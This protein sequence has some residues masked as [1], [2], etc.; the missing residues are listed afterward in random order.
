MEVTEQL[1]LIKQK[2]LVFDIET[3]K[4]FHEIAS[5]SDMGVAV[6]VAY[7]CLSDKYK[8]FTEDNVDELVS[9][10]FNADVVVGYNII[11]FDYSVLK[12]YTNKDFSSL[13]TI[14]MMRI[15][16]KGLG[17]RP[18]LD[19][20][21]SATL[22]ASK[23]ADGLQSLRWYKQG[24]IDKIIEYC[25]MD[26]KLTK[27]LYEFGKNNGYVLANNKGTIVEVPIKW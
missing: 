7:D 25:H 12:G 26:V 27:E 23:S 8:V 22:G 24:Q 17:F 20:L 18:K 14:D 6:A 5:I 13:K 2:V 11:N 1:S 19:N 10:I 3:Q 15:V 4:G 16:Q 9:E 21:T